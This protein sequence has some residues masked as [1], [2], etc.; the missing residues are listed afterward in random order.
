M[1]EIAQAGA[2]LYRKKPIAVAARQ[3]THETFREVAGWC[4]GSY[5]IDPFGY[6]R[7][8]VPS[9]EGDHEGTFGDWVLKGTQ[10]EFWVVRGDIF[11]ETYEPADGTVPDPDDVRMVIDGLA[12]KPV[13][14]LS[15]EAFEAWCRV[16]T[17]LGAGGLS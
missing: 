7:L 4:G 2:Q 10:G 16:R 15:P 3:F 17:A 1:N 14:L 5:N 13:S 11:A 6:G 12:G 8:T 9:L